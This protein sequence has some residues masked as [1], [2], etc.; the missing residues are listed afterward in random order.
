MHLRLAA[1]AVG[2][3]LLLGA[4]SVLAAS[5]AAG[6][7]NISI[8]S[9]RNGAVVH[10]SRVTVTVRV[11]NFKL[12]PPSLKNPPI[13]KRN[14]GHIHYLVDGKLAFSGVT[15]AVSHTL[16]NLSP[17]RHTLS[18]YLA[19]SQHIQ[20]PGTQAS[21]IHITVARTVGLKPVRRRSALHTGGGAGQHSS[22]FSLT[23]LI[24][25][26]LAVLMGAVILGRRYLTA[27]S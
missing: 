2:L 17:G 14:Q 26:L 15:A 12:V 13:L 3:T 22:S 1:F 10:G 23:A 18:V 24:L 27:R 11:S 9:P 8:V 4:P 6:K 19:T 16:T 20:Y 21:A 7:P 5:S 25:G